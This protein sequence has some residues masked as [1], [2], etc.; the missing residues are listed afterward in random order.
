MH[1]HTDTHEMS[2]ADDIDARVRTLEA[3]AW[4]D[5][6]AAPSEAERDR[7]GLCGLQIGDGALLIAPGVDSLLFNRSIHVPAS[8]LPRAERTLRTAGARRYLLSMPVPEVAAHR[9]WADTRALEPFSRNWVDFAREGGPP[10]P[11]P[12]LT[13]GCEVRD[14]TP[15][16]ADAVVA[17]YCAAFDQPESAGALVAPLLSRDG[18]HVV[19]GVVGGEIAGVGIAFHRGR[20]CYLVGGATAPQHRNRGLQGAMVVA[21]VRRALAA[22]RTTIGSATGVAKLGERNSSWRNL[23]RAGLAPGGEVAHLC[24]AGT[25]W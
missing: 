9:D 2:K 19:V 5:M 1:A 4:R 18:W 12:S 14:A 16:D 20:G 13:P 7:L 23:E 6:L 11:E 15:A 3:A 24:P 17:I 8:E 21:R 10:P 22:G 25:T